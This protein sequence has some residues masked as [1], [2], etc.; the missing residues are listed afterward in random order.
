MCPYPF[1]SILPPCHVR[2]SP[3]DY[4]AMAIRNTS[5]VILLK[6]NVFF[7]PR[8]RVRGG[9]GGCTVAVHHNA[10]TATSNL[11]EWVN[12]WLSLYFLILRLEKTRQS[13]SIYSTHSLSVVRRLIWFKWMNLID[14][15]KNTNSHPETLVMMMSRWGCQ[16]THTHTHTL[17]TV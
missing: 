10:S 8:G 2:A 9:G 13:T 16:H 14:F 12:E 4:M 1:L 5:D 3:L 11:S 6:L 7:V 17:V 15:R